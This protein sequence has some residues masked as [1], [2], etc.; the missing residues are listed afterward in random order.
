YMSPEQFDGASAAGHRSDLYSLGV[1][2]YECLTGE[3][4]YAIDR[5][6]IPAAAATVR[7]VVPTLLGRVD[8][9]LAGGIETVVAKLLE[10]DPADRYQSASELVEDLRRLRDGRETNARPVSML[11]RTRRRI[12]R[13][14]LRSR[15]RRALVVLVVVALASGLVYTTFR[16][17]DAEARLAREKAERSAPAEGASVLPTTAP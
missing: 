3:L 15:V 6:S 1:M 7:T 8:P 13:V 5:S 9:A 12:R 4:P 17:F 16:W 14:S 11:A 2:F 10:K